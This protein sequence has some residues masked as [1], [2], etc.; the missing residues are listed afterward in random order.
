MVVVIVA[1][2]CAWVG[3]S[4][5]W[6]QQRREM[7][8]DLGGEPYRQR[9]QDLYGKRRAPAGLWLLGE[10]GVKAIYVEEDD[11]ER[12]RWLFP[13]AEVE[14]KSEICGVSHIRVDDF[15]QTVTQDSPAD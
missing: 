1:I 15:G 9:L 11:I 6:M 12:T 5:N 7:L 4:L 10:H 2:P 14:V 3:Y 8:G 13:E